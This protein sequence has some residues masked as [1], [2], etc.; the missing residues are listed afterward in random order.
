MRV[1]IALLIWLLPSMAFAQAKIA[2]LIGNEAYDASVGVLKNSHN[3]IAVVGE[4]LRAQ[5]FDVLPPIKDA[6]RSAILGGVRELVRRLNEAGTD[7]IGFVYYS[8]HGAAEKGTNIN[9]LIPVT[10]KQ[11]GTDAFWD[12]SLKLDDVLRLLDGARSAAKFVIFDACRNELQLPTKDTSKGLIPVAEQEG[13]F[14]AYASSPG[15]TAS[16][17]GDKSGVY[18]AALAAELLRPGLDHLNL[19]QNVKETVLASTNGVQ[20]P[21]ESNGLNRRVYLT[22]QPRLDP[23]LV[24]RVSEAMEV[25]DRTKDTKEIA[26]LDAF[27]TRYKDT[28]YGELARARIEALQ[29][30]SA[31]L[32]SQL[33]AETWR[34]SHLDEEPLRALAKRQGILLPPTI[35]IVAPDL[36]IPTKFAEYLGAWGGRWSSIGRHLIIIVTSVESSGAAAGFYAQGPPNAY[37][38]DQSPAQYWMFSGSVG[39]QGLTFPNGAGS[40]EYHFKIVPGGYLFGRTVELQGRRRNATITLR[41]I[42][43]LGRQ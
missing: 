20:Q 7:S 2:L 30:K 23:A 3:D 24:P 32:T 41:R 12:D 22:G 37:T 42:A 1:T 26:I 43:G 4:A 31:S 9:Y 25:W 29:K 11:P 28:I 14:V 33:A 21:W 38:F 6:S 16:D 39:D 8:G 40:W 13:L 27:A 19:F 17:R 18:A 36:S 35:T 5:N 34:S 15:R 10:A